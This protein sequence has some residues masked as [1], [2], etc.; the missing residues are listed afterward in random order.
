MG[1]TSTY[2]PL[3]LAGPR[4]LDTPKL[5]VMVI[6]QYLIIANSRKE[7][8]L[9]SADGTNTCLWGHEDV[10]IWDGTTVNASLV[11]KR[12]KWASSFTRATFPYSSVNYLRSTL[13]PPFI[14]TKSFH[15]PYTSTSLPNLITLYTF[16]KHRAIH[17]N[18]YSPHSHHPS[19]RCLSTRHKLPRIRLVQHQQRQLGQCPH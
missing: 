5:I 11:G 6:A 16:S 19:F 2:K 7:L 8:W 17:S 14:I 15:R 9:R 13:S 10:N 4:C 18:V 1:T 12:P 3:V